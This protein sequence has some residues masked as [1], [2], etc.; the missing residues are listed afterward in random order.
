MVM[1]L[2]LRSSTIAPGANWIFRTIGQWSFLFPAR[3]VIVMDIKPSDGNILKQVLDGIGV[4]FILQQRIQTNTLLSDLME[5]SVM[6]KYSVT[7]FI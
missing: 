2:Q 1:A 7:V 6:H 4:S 5:S 3:R